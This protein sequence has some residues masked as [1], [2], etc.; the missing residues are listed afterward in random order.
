MSAWRSLQNLTA[1]AGLLLLSACLGSF[2]PGYVD[3]RGAGGRKVALYLSPWSGRVCLR[4]AAPPVLVASQTVSASGRF[5]FAS[6]ETGCYRVVDITPAGPGTPASDPYADTSSATWI[7]PGPAAASLTG[8][9]TRKD[10]GG[11]FL[12]RIC[13]GNGTPTDKLACK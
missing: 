7:Q 4:S 3:E 8:R 11:V 10:Q 9:T 12:V 2:D 5:E 1:L 13:R 6:L